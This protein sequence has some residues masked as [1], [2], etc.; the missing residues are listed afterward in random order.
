MDIES[1]N[2]EIKQDKCTGIFGKLFG[3]NFQ[4]RYSESESEGT[5]PQDFWSPALTFGRD[6]VNIINS[7][8]SRKSEYVHD[9]CVRCGKIVKIRKEV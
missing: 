3:H 6:V 5:L 2:S 9:V 1:I 8:K 4:P 7:T